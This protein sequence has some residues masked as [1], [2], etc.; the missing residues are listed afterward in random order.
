[1]FSASE[2][3]LLLLTAFDLVL[4]YGAIHK[5]VIHFDIAVK[6]K[7]LLIVKLR[8]WKTQRDISFLFKI[9]DK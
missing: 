3:S 8:S 5:T 6:L 2:L 7:Q 4:F 1:M 9:H